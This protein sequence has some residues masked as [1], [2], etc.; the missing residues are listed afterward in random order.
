MRGGIAANLNRDPPGVL[1]L[2]PLDLARDRS[3]W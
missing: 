1:P 3:L 2:A